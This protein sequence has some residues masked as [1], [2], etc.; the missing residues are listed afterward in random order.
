MLEEMRYVGE[1]VPRDKLRANVSINLSHSPDKEEII[2][3][4]FFVQIRKSFLS[5]SSFFI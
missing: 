1:S 3:S 2:F 4:L 5:L